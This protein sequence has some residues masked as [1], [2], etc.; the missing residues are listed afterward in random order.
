MLAE[1]RTELLLP[2][3]ML[4]FWGGYTCVITA[5]RPNTNAR[6]AY[7]L[8]VSLWS[9]G[10]AYIAQTF[11]M[12]GHERLLSFAL[13]TLVSVTAVFLAVLG[14]REIRRKPAPLKGRGMAIGA[15]VFSA[16]AL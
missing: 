5:K 13:L 15:I 3:A 12:L 1:M 4:F 7:S 9:L 11:P 6:C 10:L 2:L 8:G 14:L 16:I